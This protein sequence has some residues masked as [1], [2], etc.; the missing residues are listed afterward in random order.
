MPNRFGSFELAGKKKKKIRHIVFA[1][2]RL[3]LVSSE[4]TRCR[5]SISSIKAR[6]I[7]DDS[8]R[9]GMY[10]GAVRGHRQTLPLVTFPTP[11][12]L[13]P[14]SSLPVFVGCKKPGTMRHGLHGSRAPLVLLLLLAMILLSVQNTAAASRFLRP[15]KPG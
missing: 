1:A 9:R 3:Y 14:P 4:D 6:R 2:D 15:L 8:A 11:S 13:P 10:L 7:D 5:A 12:H